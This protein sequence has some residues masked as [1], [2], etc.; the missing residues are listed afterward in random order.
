MSDKLNYLSGEKSNHQ[1]IMTKLITTVFS[2]LIATTSLFAAESEH[3]QTY[4]IPLDSHLTFRNNQD[5]FH[6]FDGD[7]KVSVRYE[8]SSHRD[9]DHLVI[10]VHPDQA[11]L[12]SLPYLTLFDSA[13][14]YAKD[15]YIL[16]S[17]EILPRLIN[18]KTKEHLIKHNDKVYGTAVLTLNKLSGGYECDQLTFTANIKKII[19]IKTENKYMKIKNNKGC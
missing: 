4:V 18:T 1:I 15:I 2:L 10:T 17:E 7:V 3:K 16:N 9:Y 8:I 5:G 12:K 11:S 6:H 13:K 14:E 19:S